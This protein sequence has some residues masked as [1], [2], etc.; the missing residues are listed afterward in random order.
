[1][2]V[3]QDHDLAARC[4]GARLLKHFQVKWMP[5]RVKKMRHNKDLE[6]ILIP[7]NRKALKT[8]SA[9]N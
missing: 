3:F 1:M 8:M 9:S 5:V 4:T 7:R 2:V 6:R